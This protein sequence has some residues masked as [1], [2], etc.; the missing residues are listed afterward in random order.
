MSFGYDATKRCPTCRQHL[1][2]TEYHR[3]ASRPDGLQGE[4]K[5]CRATRQRRDLGQR[6]RNRPP[7]SGYHAATCYLP[8]DLRTAL[9]LFAQ[10]EGVSQSLIMER[11]IRTEVQQL[12]AEA[13]KAS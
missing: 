9:K 8:E 4:C 10:R 11:A 1:P 13:R 2:R 6:R 5:T 12:I 7:R 3:C